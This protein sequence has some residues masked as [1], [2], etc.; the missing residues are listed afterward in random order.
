LQDFARDITLPY[1]DW[2][3]PHYKPDKPENGCK[4]LQALQA[5]LREPELEKVL[6]KG[7]GP[8][9]GRHA[10][11]EVPQAGRA[12]PILHFAARLLL[13]C[14]QHDRLQGRHALSEEPLSL[15]AFAPELRVGLVDA[16]GLGA[17]HIGETVPPPI[18]P[19]LVHLGVWDVFAAAGHCPSYRTVAA[20]GDPR[21]TGNEFLV[22]TEQAGWRLDRTA[23]NGM[24]VQAAGFRVAAHLRAKVVAL[25]HEAH[26]W[27]V[28]LSDGTT[29]TAHFIVDATGRAATLA[30]RCGFRPVN[31]DRL[32][33][34]WLTVASCSDG[35]EG[36]MIETFA[37]GWWYTAATPGGGRVIACM[38][39]AD[40]V[41]PLG[42]SC[43]EGFARLLAETRH[44]RRVADI[45][46]PLGR[47]MIWPAG[48]RQLE[49]TT[50]LPLLCVGD[51]AICYDPLSGQGIVKALRCGI[52]ASYGIA[53]WLRNRDTRGLA[54]YRLMLEC[55]FVAYSRA[56]RDYYAQEQRWPDRPFWRRRNGA[57]LGG[58]HCTTD[59]STKSPL[60][61]VYTGVVGLP[62]LA[63]RRLGLSTPEEPQTARHGAGRGEAG[64]DRQGQGGAVADAA[65]AGTRQR[66]D[67]ADQDRPQGPPD[68]PRADEN[69]ASAAGDSN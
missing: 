42:L 69:T 5:F 65:R 68:G 28:S 55:E 54:R 44:V 29:H 21:L 51:A 13:P 34:C 24:L 25:A 26:G 23:F 50:P 8:R 3:M 58:D 62:L 48:S 38:T 2:T 37:E 63:R 22:H 19:V 41:R 27:C 31:L 57:S 20:W 61:D 39:D 59:D 35:T 36:L 32:I 46:L 7:G 30:R 9:A 11:K 15:A 47:P 43:G 6:G 16:S 49:G 66:K 67:Q 60:T 45:N 33:G 10:E 64:A 17:A 4:I 18:K 14:D 56:L 53:D 52:F 12:A 1:W 40:R